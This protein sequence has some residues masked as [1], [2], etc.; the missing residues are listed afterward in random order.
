MDANATV[1]KVATEVKQS[2][3]KIKHL[4]KELKEKKS[5]L[6]SKQKEATAA[7][8]EYKVRTAEVEKITSALTDLGFDEARMDFLDKVGFA[9]DCRCW[10]QLLGYSFVPLAPGAYD[11][12]LE[13]P[14]GLKR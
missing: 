7:E 1:G 8:K 2:R 6:S 11:S 12:Y 14:I 13:F 10:V 5:Q 4:E 9:L 3:M